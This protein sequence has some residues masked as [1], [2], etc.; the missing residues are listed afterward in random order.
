[1]ESLNYLIIMPRTVTTIG[2]GYNFPLGVAYVSAAMKKAGLSVFTLNL[3]HINGDTDEIIINEILKN[4][5]DVAMT[6]GLSF[7]YSMLKRIV[8]CIYNNFPKVR[9]IVG[10]GIITADPETAMIAL[11]HADF[12]IIGEGEITN[13]ELCK[14]MEWNG[15]EWN[16]MEWNGMEER[17]SAIAGIIFMVD[18]KWTRTEPREEIMDLD[19]LPFPDYD[20]FGLKQ[21][22][23]LPPMSIVNTTSNR[24]FFVNGSRSCPYQCTFCFHTTGKKYRQRSID[25]IIN[26]VEI[27]VNKYDVRHIIFN[28]ELFARKKERVKAIEETAKRLNITWA[29]S[30]RVDDIDVELIEIMRNGKCVSMNLGLES[31]SNTV[32]KSM[33]KKTTIEQIDNALAL[34]H[35]AGIPSAGN[36]IFGDIEETI[37][38]ATETLRYW[39]NHKE[40]GID[41]AFIN[42]YPGTQL[43]RYALQNQLIKNAV[44]FLK[45]GCPQINVSKLTD[46][47]FS[48]IAETMLELRTYQSPTP[49]DSKMLSLDATGRMTF[50][51]ICTKCNRENIWENAKLMVGNNWISCIYCGQKHTPP[52]PQELT[53]A[54]IKNIV[55]ISNKSR[56][57]GLWGITK[58]TFG[59]F[60]GNSIFENTN[61]IFIDNASAK[62]KIRLH[63]KSV[64]SPDILLSGEIDTVIFFYPNS[65]AGIAD[66]VKQKYPHIK[67][68]ISVYDI[69]NE[70]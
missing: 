35:D 34:I 37:E 68:F 69:L 31:A 53:D 46:N 42:V 9:I 55:Q 32:L 22:L 60:N 62:Q 1:M 70:S 59:I 50:T 21:Y 66:E 36:F 52:V 24:A 63:G 10:G 20:G 43:Y 19:A 15:M 58:D 2:E 65:W 26:E 38:T 6:G 7:Q 67:M 4:K 8:D 3:N 56:K 14:A 49:K 47:D 27:L 40:Y 11:E 17:Y 5:I 28:D 30:F 18:G 57:I 25:S 12:G 13:V 48:H 41:L 61:F 16:G 23:K 33:R 39:E 54:I 45:D 51:G 64:H 44:Q 29:G